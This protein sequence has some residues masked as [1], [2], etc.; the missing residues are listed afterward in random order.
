MAR[1]VAPSYLGPVPTK[2]KVLLAWMAIGV[3]ASL[4][5]RAWVDVALAAALFVGVLRAKA[6]ARSALI[7]LA[8][9]CIAVIVGGRAFALIMSSVPLARLPVFL[10]TAALEVSTKAFVIWCLSQDDVRAWMTERTAQ[11]MLEKTRGTG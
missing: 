9:L 10:A 8:W 3:V 5:D 7:A 2:L 1:N 6:S 4:V 11:R